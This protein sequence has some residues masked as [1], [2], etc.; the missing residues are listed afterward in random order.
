MAL[1]PRLGILSERR[2]IL[3]HRPDRASG[4]AVPVLGVP[5]GTR[6]NGAAGSGFPR[7]LA[8]QPG[9]PD[10]LIMRYISVT[11][12]AVDKVVHIFGCR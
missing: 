12:S 6:R 8:G 9:Y 7:G 2:P 4:T 11:P 5:L 3:H 10:F 1:Q